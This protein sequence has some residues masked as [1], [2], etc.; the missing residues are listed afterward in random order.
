M[1]TAP[2]C[3]PA[4]DVISSASFDHHKVFGRVIEGVDMVRQLMNHSIAEDGTQRWDLHRGLLEHIDEQS[5]IFISYGHPSTTSHVHVNHYN[6]DAM[7][8]C[9]FSDRLYSLH[10][11]WF[12]TVAS[13]NI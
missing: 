5:V 9:L 7:F 1:I 12:E 6:D 4:H 13:Y 8:V 2:P 11:E 3:A 10:V